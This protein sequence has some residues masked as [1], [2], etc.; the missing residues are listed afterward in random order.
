M[1]SAFLK[2]NEFG[3]LIKTQGQ[4]YDNLEANDNEEARKE[5]FGT[6]LVLNP[7]KKAW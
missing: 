4:H 1:G 6:I 3:N 7:A 2:S 5:S